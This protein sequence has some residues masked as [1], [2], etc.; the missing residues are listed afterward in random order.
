[1]K[2]NDIIEAEDIENCINGKAD[3]IRLLK[4][5]KFIEKACPEKAKGFVRA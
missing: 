4:L 3:D 1:M 5:Y 2:L